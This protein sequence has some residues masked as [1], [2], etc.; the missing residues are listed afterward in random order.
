MEKVCDDNG[1]LMQ[2][3]DVKRELPYS[4]VFRVAVTMDSVLV[5][6]YTKW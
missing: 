3:E 1:V 5:L 2:L 6:S 4:M